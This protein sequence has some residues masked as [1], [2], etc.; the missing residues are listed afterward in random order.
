ME[1]AGRSPESEFDQPLIA[2]DVVP[3][4]FSVVDG[5]RVGTATRL[6]EPYA[7][8][9]ALPGVLLRSGERLGVAAY[10]ALQDKTGIHASDVLRTVQLGAFDRPGRDPRS[11]AISIAFLAIVTPGS[12]DHTVWSPTGAELGLPFDHD[13]IIDAAL[14]QARNRL[15]TDPAT[16]R[17]LTGDT[18]PGNV[19]SSLTT[20]LT[21]K[22]PILSN[23]NRV[24]ASNPNVTKLSGDSTG[25]RGRAALWKWNDWISTVSR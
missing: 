12:G 1:G 14:E 13:A 8:H 21:G 17:A 18:F 19:A 23:L 5:L 4:A 2:I 6:F 7:G 24:L 16:T 15:W 9:Q 11:H 22:V 10:R 20:A 25:G 3:L